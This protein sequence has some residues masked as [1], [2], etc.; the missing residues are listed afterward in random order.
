MP[1]TTAVKSIAYDDEAHAY[2]LNGEPVPSVTQILDATCPKPA[3]TWWGFRVGLAA[4]V[5]LLHLN[6]I[7]FPSLIGHTHKELVEGIPTAAN[8]VLN[9]SKKEK[10]ALEQKAIE[11]KL[12]PNNIKSVAAD[13]GT[14]IHDAINR[15]GITGE[16]PDLSDFDPEHRGYIQGLSR[17]WFQQDPEFVA[18]EKL[19][20]SAELGYAG[21]LDLEALIEGKRYLIDFKTSKDVYESMHYQLAGYQFAEAEMGTL[22]DHTAVVLLGK[23]GSYQMVT[24]NASERLWRAHVELWKALHADGFIKAP[25]EKKARK[26]EEHPK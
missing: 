3:L 21:R 20:A 1:E 9:R 25:W 5:E 10:V 7:S 24:G 13:R 22:Y 16:L 12:D 2:K 15:M 26:T 14:L 6:E 4:V 11:R 18:Q 23:D 17:W 19:V 8:R